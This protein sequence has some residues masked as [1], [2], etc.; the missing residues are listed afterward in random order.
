MCSS[1]LIIP[2]CALLVFSARRPLG[3]RVGVPRL[4]SKEPLTEVLVLPPPCFSSLPV[5]LS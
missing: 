3:G 2:G 5:H 1:F 4:L